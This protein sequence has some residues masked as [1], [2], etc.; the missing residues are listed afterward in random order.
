MNDYLFNSEQVITE[1]GNGLITLTTHRIRYYAK[2][3]QRSHLVSI[4]L[5]NVSSISLRYRSKPFYL[6]LAI[7]GF[8]IAAWLLYEEG[9][10][11]FIIPAA[12]GL[13]L[14]VLYFLS[15]KAA[16]AIAS[17]GGATI[18]FHTTNMKRAD[19]LRFINQIEKGIESHRVTT[20]SP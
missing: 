11:S 4:M 19:Q 2:S 6:A 7:I 13:F 3:M 16:L 20:T 9:D 14:L 15:R 10:D 1:S 8:A 17:K 12:V 5:S 18:Y